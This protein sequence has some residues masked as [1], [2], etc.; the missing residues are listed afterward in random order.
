MKG[1]SLCTARFGGLPVKRVRRGFTSCNRIRVGRLGSHSGV[2]CAPGGRG[3]MFRL[4]MRCKT[5]RHRFPGLNCTTRLVGG[6]NVVKTCRPRRLGRRLDGLGTAYRIATSS[7]GLCVVVRNCRTALPRTYRLLSHRV[8]VPGLSRGRLTHL[9]NS[10]VNVHRRH[11]SGIDVLGRTLQ[12]CVLCK[13][14]SSCVGRLASGRVCRLRVSRLANSV[15]HTSGCRTG[16]FFAKALPFSRMCSVL[17]GGLPLITGRHPSGSPRTGSV[18]PI[19]RGAICFLPGGSTRRTRVR[20]CVPVRGTSG[21][22]S[23]LHDTF[24]RCFNLSFANVILGRVH[25]GHSVTCATCT[26]INARNVTKGTDCLHNCVNARGS[27]TGSTLSILV[28]LIG[29]VPGGPRHVSGV[30]DCLHRTV[31]ADRPDFHGGTVRLMSLNCEN[32]ASSPT[33]RGLPGMSTLAFSSVIGFCRRGVGSGP[34]YVSVV[35]GPGGVS[36]GQLRGF[37]GMIGLG[38]HGLFGAGSTLFWP[39]F[40]PLTV[41]SSFPLVEKAEGVGSSPAFQFRVP[42]GLVFGA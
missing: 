27:G 7:S 32:C 31:L 19:A 16:I 8:L 23:I 5:N 12:R 6:T 18:V 4:I 30:G 36:L 1:R 24:G 33:G 28:N 22:S 37:N 20:L 21:G 2:C 9:G 15:G 3:G 34:C 38:R 40:V 11:G 39:Y 26:F 41:P 17:D 10:T 14:G 13:R 25:R 42:K 29:S 35:N